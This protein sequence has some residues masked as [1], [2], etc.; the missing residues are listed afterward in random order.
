[1]V[2]APDFE[3]LSRKKIINYLKSKK[4]MI[5]FDNKLNII[6]QKKIN[7]FYF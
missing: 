3:K 1:M 5:I 7:F 2:E 4:Y 6:F